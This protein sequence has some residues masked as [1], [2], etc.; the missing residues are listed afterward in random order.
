MCVASVEKLALTA[1]EFAGNGNVSI[2]MGASVTVR[3]DATFKWW[4]Q[5]ECMLLLDCR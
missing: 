4:E 3:S 2:C 1:E 5:R